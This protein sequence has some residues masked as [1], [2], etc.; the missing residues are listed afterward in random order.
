MAVSVLS[1]VAGTIVEAIS[2]IEGRS[3]DKLPQG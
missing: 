2:G 3:V 1:V